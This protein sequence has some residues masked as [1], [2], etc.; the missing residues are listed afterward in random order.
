MHVTKKTIISK[1]NNGL[2]VLK[3]EPTCKSAGYFLSMISDYIIRNVF[4]VEF[5][6]TLEQIN[7]CTCAAYILKKVILAHCSAALKLL[8]SVSVTGPSLII[9]LGGC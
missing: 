7:K 3:L 1:A 9:V 5:D 8:I 2:K 4:N 6:T